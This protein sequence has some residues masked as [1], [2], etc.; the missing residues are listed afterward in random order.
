MKKDKEPPFR[1]GF[2]R[3][4]WEEAKANDAGIEFEPADLKINYV[5]P[6]RYIADFRLSNGIIIEAK[7]YLRPRDRTKMRKIKEQNP[8]L[9]IRFIFQVADK[10]L[11]KSKNSETYG[12]WAE[13][14]GYKWAE[15]TIPLSWILEKPQALVVKG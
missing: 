8:H 14:L 12:E 5:I 6:Y 4:I 13:R 2:E 3:T 10:R 9:D 11:S 7:G 1:S 15:K